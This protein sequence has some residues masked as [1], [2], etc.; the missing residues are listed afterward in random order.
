MADAGILTGLEIVEQCRQGRISIIGPNGVNILDEA[1][2]NSN[3]YDLT[4]GDRVAVYSNVMNVRACS[5]LGLRKGIYDHRDTEL[6]ADILADAV[7]RR[8]VN[9]FVDP[10]RALDAKQKLNVWEFKIDPGLGWLL[11]PGIG[12]LM[13]TVERVSTMSYVPVLDGKSSI[14]RLFLTV[15]VTA[16]YG[17]TGFDGQYPLEVVAQYPTIVYPGMRFGQMRFHTSVGDVTD[18]KSRGNYTGE[19]SMGPVPSMDYRQFK[20]SS[21]GI[22]AA[23]D[24]GDLPTADSEAQ[25]EARTARTFY[26]AGTA[27]KIDE[28]LSFPPRSGRGCHNG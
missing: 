10:E 9:L 23:V 12:Y 25:N 15:H 24:R 26:E 17:D 28:S 19:A 18:Y 20:S 21:T 8:G 11:K 1:R 22:N 5:L 4:L 6:P 16:G 27:D 7:K 2:V 13:H 14:G 3:S